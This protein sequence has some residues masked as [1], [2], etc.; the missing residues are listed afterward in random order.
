M[1]LVNSI[2]KN[3]RFQIPSRI[4]PA[5]GSSVEESSPLSSQPAEHAVVV[6]SSPKE[7][8]TTPSGT[9]RSSAFGV[10]ASMKLKKKEAKQE[11][12]YDRLHRLI[13]E[14]LIT[15]RMNIKRSEIFIRINQQTKLY[16]ELV[17][18][19]VFIS[20]FY[21]LV[22]FLLPIGQN[23][24][25]NSLLGGSG[26]LLWIVQL[27]SDQTAFNAMN[28][29][30]DVYSYITDKL[31]PL[32]DPG[33]SLAIYAVQVGAVRLRQVRTKPSQCKTLG[34][35]DSW[36]YKSFS[37]Q[38][39]D[40]DPLIG[41]ISNKPYFWGEK[42]FP[43]SLLYASFTFIRDEG[44]STTYGTGGY[45][46]DLPLNITE[47][48]SSVQNLQADGWISEATRAITINLS[49]FNQHTKLFTVAE[50]L[51]EFPTTGL[52]IPTPRF[53]TVRLE[54]LES[55]LS[56]VFC[57]VFVCF[58]AGYIFSEMYEMF[59]RGL[60]G[61]L[62]EWWNVLEIMALTS[63][64]MLIAYFGLF[65]T[66]CRIV[67]E[68]IERDP[69][70]QYI[71]LQ[72][73]AQ[74]LSAVQELS[75][76]NIWLASI[77]IF[78]FLRLNTRL[79]LLWT[80]L[81][82]AS[83]DLA[84]FVC[85]F[86][87][88]FAGYAFMGHVIFGY[89][90]T[91]YHSFTS[92]FAKLFTFIG[93]DSGY[94]DL[95]QASPYSGVVFFFT[96]MVMCV[97]I[98]VNVFIAIINKYYEEACNMAEKREEDVKNSLEPE[99]QYPLI[100]KLHRFKVHLVLEETKPRI[101]VV[102][103]QRFKIWLIPDKGGDEKRDMHPD[104]SVHGGAKA[105][106][107]D[108]RGRPAYLRFLP[109]ILQPGYPLYLVSGNKRR[110][111]VIL[112]YNR[113]G[114]TPRD[115][116]QFLECEAVTDGEVHSW[117]NIHLGLWTC[118]KHV[119]FQYV[120]PAWARSRRATE[121]FK[122]YNIPRPPYIFSEEEV[123]KIILEFAKDNETKQQQVIEHSV[124]KFRLED[125][126]QEI[127]QL[128]MA[129]ALKTTGTALDETRV[130]ELVKQALVIDDMLQQMRRGCALTPVKKT[131]DFLKPLPDPSFHQHS[132]SF[133]SIVKQIRSLEQQ[134]L[135][136][137]RTKLAQEPPIQTLR[138]DELCYQ[139]RLLLG[140]THR[141][142][143]YSQSD[144]KKSAVQILCSFPADCFDPVNM[145]QE[146]QAYYPRPS[147]TLAIKQS[148]GDP[149]ILLGE[150]VDLLGLVIHDNWSLSKLKD[151]WKFGTVRDNASK[152]HP[153]LVPY[154]KLS[155][156]EKAYDLDMVAQTLRMIV[157]MGYSIKPPLTQS[158]NSLLPITDQA[159]FHVNKQIPP[160]YILLNADTTKVVMTDE[161]KSLADLL[162]ENAHDLWASKRK[163][164]GWTYGPKTDE[165]L[166]THD[167]LIP[168]GLMPDTQKESDLSTVTETIRTVLALGYTI[169]L[170]RTHRFWQH[171]IS[172]K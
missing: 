36:C 11:T 17:L 56:I 25:T 100:T 153:C 141:S 73:A 40:T 60:V 104:P 123:E 50:L 28:T 93:G 23:Y 37:F 89:Q 111:S 110:P 157:L 3:A 127:R 12:E 75:G 138:F 113:T 32:L 108:A 80:T 44:Y 147:D 54:T 79:N 159:S 45:V 70:N 156:Q 2:L 133:S 1:A 77:R 167:Q 20:L 116:Y 168:Y 27:G 87:I 15:Q 46:V 41:A 82:L 99:N 6:A 143:G 171:F 53:M 55:P 126:L 117:I 161:M 34:G 71:N 101:F 68:K 115:G 85:I 98:L 124:D 47:A 160:D 83:G 95:N 76:I 35:G 4:S 67:R 57:A 78:K 162:A 102:K 130:N 92:S 48:I 62:S 170:S 164:Q 64:V 33:Q 155:E 144:I 128:Q 22:I 122:E 151:G 136:I 132:A 61:Y 120:A 63:F 109:E 52:C 19:L 21:G 51:A 140:M 81:S 112:R 152:I 94:D 9:L 114:F 97:L 10:I 59:R 106:E 5:S 125:I 39:E 91:G 86:L 88:L 165:A 42:D 166:K 169:E 121:Y 103:G 118:C 150:L 31:L 65:V 96:F 142:G 38:R 49:F 134:I 148:S 154:A 14:R 13:S 58:I 119:F 90:V 172:V 129:C 30:D 135:E 18:Y 7:R 24:E 66:E 131:D 74:L 105:I 146:F 8:A 139:L 29:R 26:A 72:S 43:Y 149:V 84:A 16:R 158:R 107:C 69:Y 163:D 137:Y 145:E